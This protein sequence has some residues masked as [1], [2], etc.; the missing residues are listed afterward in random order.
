MKLLFAEDEYY[1]RMGILTSTKWEE[2]GVNRVMTAEDGAQAWE[3]LSERPDI[4]LTDIRMPFRSGIE[5][6]R[7][8]AAGM[9]IVKSSFCPAILTRNICGRRSPSP[10]L[11]ILKNR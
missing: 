1:T 7:R 2:L 6:A 11:P 4:L 3:L 10:R 8:P 5:L 9:R